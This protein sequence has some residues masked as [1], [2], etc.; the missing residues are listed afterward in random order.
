MSYNKEEYDKLRNWKFKCLYL[1]AYDNIKPSYIVPSK[2]LLNMFLWNLLFAEKND[3]E[4][5]TSP[6]WEDGAFSCT[7]MMYEP[8]MNPLTFVRDQSSVPMY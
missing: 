4:K 5:A 2:L 7:W 8:Y 1:W 3:P 6:K